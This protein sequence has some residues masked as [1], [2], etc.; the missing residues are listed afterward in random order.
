MVWVRTYDLLF[1]FFHILHSLLITLLEPGISTK[2][3]AHL[4]SMLSLL[5]SASGVSLMLSNL[6]LVVVG[7]V[8]VLDID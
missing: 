2:E 1:L 3:S 7:S 5:F 8:G 4:T 6:E